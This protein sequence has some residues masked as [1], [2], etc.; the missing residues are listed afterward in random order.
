V[1]VP[2]GVVVN[3]SI[4]DELKTLA[5]SSGLTSETA[6]K[7]F[8]LGLK[9]QDS[10]I[11]D[12]QRDVEAQKTESIS[13]LRKEWGPEFDKNVVAAQRFVDKFGD[14]KLLAE[15]NGM[16]NSPAV[17]RTFAAIGRA[18]GEDS[19]AMP[20]ARSAAPAPKQVVTGN[21]AVDALA[22]DAAMYPSMQPKD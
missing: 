2:E 3:Q 9:M 11:A 4:V 18:L 22:N 17:M 12:L 8:D 21:A 16:E 13:Q 14:P 5:K 10:F 15:L 20:G 6:Q 1:K 7:V 19:I